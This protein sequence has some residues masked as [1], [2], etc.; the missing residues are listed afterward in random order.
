MQLSLSFSDFQS[1][2][3]FCFLKLQNDQILFL[4][5]FHFIFLWFD[6][7]KNE[8]KIFIKI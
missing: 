8:F 6:G 1:R 2:Y 5:K 3:I 7:V 4:P